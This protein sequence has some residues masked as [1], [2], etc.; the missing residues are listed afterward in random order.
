MSNDWDEEHQLELAIALSLGQ[1]P[2]TPSASSPGRPKVIDLCSD[3]EPPISKSQS[4]QKRTMGRTAVG[5]VDQSAAGTRYVEENSYGMF[6]QKTA[7]VSESLYSLPEN[8]SLG[9]FSRDM[10]QTTPTGASSF[11]HRMDR[12]AMEEERLA[13]KRKAPVSPPPR[14]PVKT[15]RQATSSDIDPGSSSS[16][17]T[18]ATRDGA[19]L[20]LTREI[21]AVQRASTPEGLG[22]QYPRGVV[23]KT[24]VRGYQRDGDVKLEEVLQKVCSSRVLRPEARDPIPVASVTYLQN[25]R[26]LSLGRALICE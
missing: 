10:R 13:R 15:A 19:K 7:E 21:H 26:Y 2:E 17:H 23:K 18:P 9:K 8:D 3:E 1:Q 25:L 11:L 6:S 4:P 5:L 24:W 12:K 14:R 20:P 16:Q 22:V